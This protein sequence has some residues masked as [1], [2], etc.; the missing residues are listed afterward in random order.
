M[1][2]G[3]E[4]EAAEEDP[5]E[6]GRGVGSSSLT[7]CESCGLSVFVRTAS[8]VVSSMSMEGLALKL[9][10][11][12]I[13]DGSIVLSA[14]AVRFEVGDDDESVVVV[15]AFLLWDCFSLSLSTTFVPFVVVVVVA[16]VVVV[17]DLS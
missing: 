4:E 11:D 7:L 9:V 13:R 10:G 3:E 1:S 16:F 12:P 5:M 14:T 8:K 17:V 15:V 6:S 2:A